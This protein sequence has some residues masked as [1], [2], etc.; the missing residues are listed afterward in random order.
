MNMLKT[1]TVSSYNLG[2]LLYF[3]TNHIILY[4]LFS[5]Q[6]VYVPLRYSL[7][8]TLTI[9]HI[10]YTIF[11]LHIT[12]TYLYATFSALSTISLSLHLGQ[13]FLCD[14]QF[15]FQLPELLLGPLG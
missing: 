11:F 13:R 7:C 10:I 4:Y 15:L 9:Y 8:L 1:N 12:Y 5:I 3:L 2:I 6:Y 14:L